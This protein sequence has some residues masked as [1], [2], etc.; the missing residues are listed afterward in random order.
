M[1]NKDF[2]SSLDDCVCTVYIHVL[3]FTHVPVCMCAKIAHVI[4]HSLYLPLRLCPSFSRFFPYHVLSLP[5]LHTL[6]PR[7]LSIFIPAS[8]TCRCH[9]SA[10]TH[11]PE[12]FIPESGIRPYW[13]KV[14]GLSGDHVIVSLLCVC[15]CAD[16]QRK[17]L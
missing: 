17:K 6:P 4:T 3:L 7:P 13:G 2:I 9:Q 1:S 11:T 8:P 15:V 16:K 12:E 14:R 10:H 5:L